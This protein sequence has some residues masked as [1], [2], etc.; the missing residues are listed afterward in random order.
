MI[1]T[2]TFKEFKIIEYEIGRG[3]TGRVLLGQ[4]LVEPKQY[5]AVKEINIK[6]IEK[7]EVKMKQIA[8][9]INSLRSLESPYIVK[10]Y[11]S[12]QTDNNLYMFLEYCED[13]D[14]RSYIDKRHGSLTES[15]AVPL[16]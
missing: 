6:L 4:W 5:V 12:V 13:G 14:L 15:E 8:N 11:G 3:T 2:K 1:K 9:E 7:D 10:L 16:L